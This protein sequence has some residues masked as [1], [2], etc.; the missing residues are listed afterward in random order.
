MKN[1]GLL[2]VARVEITKAEKQMLA[3]MSRGG[4][5]RREYRLVDVQAYA[6]TRI[7][8]HIYIQN[9]LQHFFWH[10]QPTFWL[11]N[12]ETKGFLRQT[13]ST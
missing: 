13:R 8:M 9:R 4:S 7:Y 5:C 11:A 6:F 3:Q 1:R 2:T 12:R 10:E